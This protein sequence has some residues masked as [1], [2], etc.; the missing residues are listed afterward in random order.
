MTGADVGPAPAIGSRWFGSPPVV[1][2]LFLAGYILATHLGLV[3][4][5][6]FGGLTPLWP[7]AG[8]A[9]ALLLRHGLAWWPLIVAG[10]MLTAWSL[11]Q[12]WSMGLAGGAGQSLEAIVAVLMVRR[13][14]IGS[15]FRGVPDTINF[16]LLVCLLPPLVGAGLGSLSQFAHGIVPASEWH[17]G[18]FTW[19]LGDAMGLLIVT[20]LLMSWWPWPFDRI[21]P[22]FEWFAVTALLFITGLVLTT[23][24]GERGNLLFF[25]L[26][27]FVGWLALK[28][29]T[30]GASSAVAVL[31]VLVFGMAEGAGHFETAVYIGFVG[32]AAA[33]GYLVAAIL[34]RRTELIEELRHRAEHDAVTDLYSRSMLE[35]KLR[36]LAQEPGERVQHALI[37]LDLDHFNMVNDTCGHEAGDQLLRELAA[38]LAAA[39]PEDAMLAR[40]GGDEFGI[41][42]RDT[43]TEQAEAM[44]ERM[45]RVVLDYVFVNGERRFYPGTSVGIAHFESGESSA[46]VMSR[47]DIACHSAKEAGRDR[48]HA[49]GTQ[50]LAM[51]QHHSELQWVSQFREAMDAG[52]LVLFAQRIVPL[53]AIDEAPLY[54]VLL[55]KLEEGEPVS[56]G[57]FLPVAE[58]Y[59]LMPLIDHWVMRESFRFMAAHADRDFRLNINLAAATLDRPHF[60]DNVEALITEYDIDPGRIWFEVTETVAIRNLTRAVEAMHRLR[61]RGFQFA[62]DDFGTGVASFGYLSELPVQCVKIDGEFVCGLPGDEASRIIVT[63][64]NDFATLRGI[65]CVAEWVDSESVLQ[66]LRRIGVHYGQGFYLHAPEPLESATG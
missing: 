18:F 20:P 31:A 39:L 61:E 59:G 12:P 14:G 51:R 4:R 40:M 37:Y 2:L 13:L 22:A 57:R 8:V 47:A 24:A 11:G 27:P 19:W 6:D 23:L 63:A 9:L 42:L 38:R 25:L 54:E 41:L 28:Y 3:L 5:I 34:S 53:D 65:K 1:A 7:A 48:V 16:C 21:K 36:D 50:D 46:T 62:L 45:R 26:L 17:F 30:A 52:Q 60:S 29:G 64:L 44:G 35:S 56:P 33:M 43:T 32:T 15:W 58:R 55:R 10:E 66:D 49:Y